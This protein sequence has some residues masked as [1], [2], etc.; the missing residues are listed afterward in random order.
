VH[1][2]HSEVASVCRQLLQGLKGLHGCK[3]VHLDLT[4]RNILWDTCDHALRIMN[5]GSAE[6]FPVDEPALTSYVAECHYRPP[7]LFFEDTP[8]G[9]IAGLFSPLRFP[10]PELLVPAVD[11]WSL[12]C[13]IYEV[14]SR[15]PLF[16]PQFADSTA[17][18]MVET[19]C[20]MHHSLMRDH[21]DD[22]ESPEQQHFCAGLQSLEPCWRNMV[23]WSCNPAAEKRS[24]EELQSVLM[25]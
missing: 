17:A 20:K 22:G 6:V 15:R 25:L 2:G 13:V 5:M 18:M 12:G 19:W 8:E 11:V 24:L 10:K 1:F 4:A 9:H 14:A 3:V 7:E 16:H 21:I 23:L